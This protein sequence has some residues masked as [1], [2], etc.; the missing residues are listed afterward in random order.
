MT[1]P[2][3]KCDTKAKKNRKFVFFKVQ[4]KSAL[5]QILVNNLIAFHYSKII[6][7]PPKS[8]CWQKFGLHKIMV[9]LYTP[10]LVYTL[11]I[12]IAIARV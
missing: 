2:Q 5:V 9:S 1:T 10:A 4:Q 8:N 6:C 11:L 7:D 3:R 12:V